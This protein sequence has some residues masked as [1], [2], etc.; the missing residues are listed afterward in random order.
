MRSQD[1]EKK[2]FDSGSFAA[3]SA[4]TVQ[5]SQGAGSDSSFIGFI[6][7]KT[8]C[9]DIDDEEDWMLAEALYR[10]RSA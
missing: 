1:L 10:L 3:Y 7:P 8:K 6:L 5:A 2:Y 9:V 4:A